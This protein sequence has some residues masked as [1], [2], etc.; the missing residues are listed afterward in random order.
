ML[1]ISNRAALGLIGLALSGCMQSMPTAESLTRPTAEAFARLGAW[2]PW[3]PA[4]Q[5]PQLAAAEPPPAPPEAAPTPP[6]VEPAVAPGQ[7]RRRVERHQSAPARNVARAQAMPAAAAPARAPAAK[8]G[9]GL[10]PA[11]MSC[12]ATSLPGERVRME[13]KPA[14]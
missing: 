4:P 12:Q 3:A 14:D 5:Q 8:D 7:Q 1:S 9:T 2:T 10:V 11:R 6:P 13:C